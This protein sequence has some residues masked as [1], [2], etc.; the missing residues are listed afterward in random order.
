MEGEGQKIVHSTKARLQR[1]GFGGVGLGGAELEKRG[2]E[3][4][5]LHSDFGQGGFEGHFDHYSLYPGF[6]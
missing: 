6:K 1:V 5:H 2:G 4:L 3:R